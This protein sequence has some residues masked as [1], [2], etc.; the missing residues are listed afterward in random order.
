MFAA[1][2]DGATAELYGYLKN[3]MLL[4]DVVRTNQE[5]FERIGMK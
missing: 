2:I 1:F 3:D 4:V 5:A